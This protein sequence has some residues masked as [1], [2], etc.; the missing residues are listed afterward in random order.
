MEKKLDRRGVS[1]LKGMQVFIYLPSSI[2]QFLASRRRPRQP[3]WNF[4]GTFCPLE[5]RALRIILFV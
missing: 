5:I 2:Y 3:M 1:H 4:V